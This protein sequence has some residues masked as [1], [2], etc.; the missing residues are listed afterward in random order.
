MK[1]IGN[2]LIIAFAM[3]SK[4]PMPRADWE[5]E[6]M[7][8]VLCAFPLVGVVIGACIYG[9]N[10]MATMFSFG[11][12]LSAAGYVL[13]PVLLTGGIHLDGF[14][15]TCDALHSYASTEKKLEILKDP[16]VGAFA[17]IGGCSLFAAN[18]GLWSQ[19]SEKGAQALALSF[20]MSRCLSGFSVVY[21][22][23][24]KNSGL[25]A[26]FQD[27]AHRKQVGVICML[28]LLLVFAVGCFWM[29]K[30][31]IFMT[32]AAG[33]TFF[34]YVRMARRQFG[35]VTGD[36]AGFFLQMCECLMAAF[37]VIGE[38]L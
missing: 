4:I 20:V 1:K 22:P 29:P 37:V 33:I 13:L 38:C 31:M 19:V 36:L 6:N 26:T 24:A 2:S 23:C 30:N 8:Y 3:Y 10:M 21:L 27:G 5:K 34:C 11:D 17:V 16:H 32:A 25:A 12:G 28:E 14:L 15:D 35:G 18:F 9:W 7:R